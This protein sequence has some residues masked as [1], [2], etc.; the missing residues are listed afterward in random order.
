MICRRGNT[1]HEC[2]YNQITL[3][4]LQSFLNRSYNIQ[5]VKTSL[6]F[7][8]CS[9]GPG[10]IAKRKVKL[11]CVSAEL[12]LFRLFVQTTGKSHRRLECG[13]WKFDDWIIEKLGTEH[14]RVAWRI[15]FIVILIASTSSSPSSSTSC[16][17]YRTLNVICIISSFL[18]SVV[19]SLFFFANVNKLHVFFIYIE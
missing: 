18:F 19:S 3:V 6:R 7:C 17:H 4:A 12:N 1:K 13:D 8:R 11:M 16:T 9:D 5:V 2:L 15:T 14:T 10:I